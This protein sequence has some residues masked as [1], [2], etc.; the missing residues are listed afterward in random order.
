MKIKIYND[1]TYNIFYDN[2]D[3]VKV[4]KEKGSVLGR[5]IKITGRP[6]TAKLT[7]E[8][9]DGVIDE[10][11]WNVVP[12]T[13]DGIEITKDQLF[14]IVPVTESIYHAIDNNDRTIIKFNEFN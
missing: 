13:E 2:G 9:K 7:I 12:V 4:K 8:T 6:I 10:Y 5:V 1:K 3:Y 14:K 11:V